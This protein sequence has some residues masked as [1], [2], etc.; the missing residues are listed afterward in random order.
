MVRTVLPRVVLAL[1]SLFATTPTDTVRVS[2]PPASISIEDQPF[3][4]ASSTTARF[5]AV[6]PPEADSATTIRVELHRR[7]TSR[8]SIRVI[9]E[10]NTDVRTIDDVDV[11]VAS[12]GRFGARGVVIPVDIQLQGSSRAI[13]LP[14]PGVYPVTISAMNGADVLATTRTFIAYADIADAARPVPASV[15]LTQNLPPSRTPDGQLL[16][17]STTRESVQQLVTV[18]NGVR[19]PLTVQ[20]QPETIASLADSELPSD[21]SLLASLQRALASHMVLASTYVPIDPSSAAAADLTEEFTRQLRLGESTIE[22]VLPN[23]RVTRETWISP[24]PMTERGASLLRDLGV[25]TLVL[26][27][28]QKAGF[29]SERPAS[30]VAHVTLQDGTLVSTLMADE[31]AA[32]LLDD[33]SRDTTQTGVRL[34]AELVV[35]RANLIASGAPSDSLRFVVSSSTGETRGAAATVALMTALG[36]TP[37]IT[38]TDFS[39]G[40]TPAA[41]TP[42]VILPKNPVRDMS[43][44][45]TAIFSLGIDRVAIGSMLPEDDP[46][47]ALWDKLIAIIPATSLKNP[48][49]FVFGL[50]KL[51]REVK[52]NV[53]PPA[54]STFT[55]GD[56][57][58]SIRVQIRNSS[59]KVLKVRVTLSSAKL[60]FPQPPSVVDLA[61]NASTDVVVPVIARSNGRFPVTVFVTTPVGDARVTTPIVLTARV[62]IIA[63]LGQL[64]SFVALGVLLLWWLVSWRRSRHRRRATTVLGS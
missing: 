54:P 13:N 26:L 34:A 50:R 31:D 2:T 36:S 42:A 7:A 57:R 60:L 63:G 18:L 17:T 16:I 23:V 56:R 49:D 52:L 12:L 39:D 55:L 37:G 62:N 33:A 61:P 3:A 30:F 59:K 44:V 9:A 47:P 58:A 64:I 29:V 41:Q 11:P 27:S 48:D 53:T 21:K 51:M 6:L 15:V 28:S 43:N 22:R 20:L 40:M 46:E 35:E 1:T 10:G 45:G 38:V 8:E 24:E 32:T 19:A 4:I 5:R 14:Y 25:S